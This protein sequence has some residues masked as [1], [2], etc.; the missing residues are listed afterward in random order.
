MT[1]VSFTLMCRFEVTISQ[2]HDDRNTI[3]VQMAVSK[4][5]AL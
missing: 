5:V 2:S 3:I 4:S 1:Q